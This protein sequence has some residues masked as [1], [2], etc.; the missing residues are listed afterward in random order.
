M[1]IG[2]KFKFRPVDQRSGFDSPVRL[3]LVTDH[4]QSSPDSNARFAACA[5]TGLP[6]R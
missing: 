3:A 1:S 2:N 4:R 5:C 6:R